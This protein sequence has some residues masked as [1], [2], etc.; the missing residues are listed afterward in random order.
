MSAS[1]EG[2]S[3]DGSKVFFTTAQ[4][5]LNGDSDGSNDLYMAEVTAAGVQ[6][7]VQVSRGAA[8]DPTPGFGADV[9]GAARI[10]PDGSHV[11]FVARGVLTTT[12]NDHGEAA[13]GGAFNLYEYD[14]AKAETQ[15]VAGLASSGELTLALEAE[16]IR[17]E[18][19]SFSKECEERVLRQ[20]ESRLGVSHVDNRPF[21]TSADGRFLV[22][23]NARDLTAP[24]DTSTVVQV[25]EYDAQTKSLAR[26]SVGQ[27]SASFPAGYNENGNTTNGEYFASILVPF[28][29]RQDLPA[30]EVSSLSVAE[31]GT[32]V[33][34]SRNALTPQAVG[35]GKNIYE[36]REGNVYLVSAGEEQSLEE[37]VF[38][39]D[40]FQPGEE[41]NR[42]LLGIDRAGTD[43]FF[44]STDAL[45]PGDTDTQ[46]DWY[47]A[48][49]NG[50]FP[51]PSAPVE[52]SGE[53]C[54]GQPS[55]SQ[56]LPYAGSLAEPG[57]GNLASP[58]PKP[59]GK[60]KPPSRAQ[61]LRRALRACRASRNKQNRARCEISARKKYGRRM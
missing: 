25:F 40:Y 59:S 5:L 14:V 12:P 29:N 60:T 1:F 39:E 50:G 22:F 43:V 24:E 18:G 58:V 19:G 26:V 53:S 57:G 61:K 10:S 16:C 11:Y 34:T 8:S 27:K 38:G 44:A 9:M 56:T 2:A 17:E 37:A 54:Q 45:L 49:V 31:D 15:F 46:A 51:A 4:P 30:G 21:Q 47:A 55:A 52:C 36:Y 35:G 13:E 7:L 33:F 6:N 42:R 32:V 20:T 23:V 28:Y 48:R 3:T 41:R